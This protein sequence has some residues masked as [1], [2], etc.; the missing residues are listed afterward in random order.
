MNTIS[1][2]EIFACVEPKKL[3]VALIELCSLYI[4]EKTYLELLL[5]SLTTQ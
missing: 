5:K 3:I 4:N 1:K 2:E